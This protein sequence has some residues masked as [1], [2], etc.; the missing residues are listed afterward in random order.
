MALYY[1][2][3]KYVARSLRGRGASCEVDTWMTGAADVWAQWPTGTTWR[4]QVKSTSIP[5][6]APA[7]PNNEELRRL[8]MTTTKND[9]TPVIA[10]VY[11]DWTVEYYSANSYRRLKPPDTR[12]I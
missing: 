8:K 3:E 10:L 6:K 11:A 7:W 5:G 9:E 2:A 12:N 1:E 4:I